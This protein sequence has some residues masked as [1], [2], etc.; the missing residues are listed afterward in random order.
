MEVGSFLVRCLASP[1][2]AI[3][4]KVGVQIRKFFLV[5]CLASPI[6]ASEEVSGQPH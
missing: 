4:L 5:R 3:S 2:E 6:E 1:I